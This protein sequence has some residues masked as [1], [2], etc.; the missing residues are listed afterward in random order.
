MTLVQWL[1]TLGTTRAATNAGAVLDARHRAEAQVDAVARRL[2][3]RV[4]TAA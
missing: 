4:P 3:E 2:V 1:L